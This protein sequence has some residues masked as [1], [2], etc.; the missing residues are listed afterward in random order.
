M[1]ASTDNKKPKR[2]K[3]KYHP[4]LPIGHSPVW[5]WPPKPKAAFIWLTKRWVTLSTAT[6]F[7]SFSLIVFNYFQPDME[8]MKSLSFDWIATIYVRNLVLLLVV[9]GALHLFLFT[10]TAQGDKLKFDARPMMKNNGMYAFRDQVRDN[11]FWS[12]AGGLTA[13]TLLE[14]LYFWG[15]A[16]G[17]APVLSFSDAPY[18]IIFSVFLISPFRS[19]HFYWIHRML[20]WP[21][22]Y[23]RVHYVHHRNINV[24][25]WSGLSMHPGESLFYFTTVLIHFVVPSHPVIF[26]FHIY[27]HA[28]GPAFSHAGFEKL[29]LK[30]KKLMA[31]GQF[32]HQLH[33]R[34]FECNYGTTEMPWDEWFGSFHDGSEEATERVREVQRRKHAK[35]GTS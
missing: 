10:F 20:H 34:F 31:A 14:A 18:W 30:D 29:L 1:V 28:L 6:L 12:F 16:N 27:S 19:M 32:H 24:G 15:A 26:L 7:M 13:W 25:P 4:K 23:S 22:L 21:P 3:W 2:T 5:A 35:Y 8:T 17:Y 33:H 11:M 9:A